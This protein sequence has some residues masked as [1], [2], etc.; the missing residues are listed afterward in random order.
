MGLEIGIFGRDRCEAQLPISVEHARKVSDATGQ[1]SAKQK[2]FLSQMRK[3][4]GILS[5]TQTSVAGEVGRVALRSLYDLVIRGG[6]KVDKEGWM[7]PRVGGDAA[8][9]N[10]PQDTEAKR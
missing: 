5:F 7:G 2:A 10:G 1:I 8:P 6:G 4:V 3:L 9:E